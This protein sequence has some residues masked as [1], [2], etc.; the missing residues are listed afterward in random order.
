MS[1]LGRF[2]RQI[3]S[4]LAAT[5][6]SRLQLPLP[7]GEIRRTILPYRANRRALRLES[8]EDYELMLVRLCAGEGGFARTEPEEAHAEFAA[9]AQS[10][11]PDLGI[12]ERHEAATVILNPEQVAR[13]RNPVSEIAFA[14]PDQRYAPPTP[15]IQPAA[16]SPRPV[17][18]RDSTETKSGR[19][20]A[21]CGSCGEKLPNGRRAKFCPRCGQGQALTQCPECQADLEPSWRHCVNC[22]A[23][24][25]SR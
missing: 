17:S 7:V 3:V 4:N 15:P 2:F 18:R 9:E 16:K 23:T 13:A 5:D 21:I 11:N 24:L 19:P 20:A 25:H 8:S 22:G 1:D 6:P 10:S 14:P 12:G